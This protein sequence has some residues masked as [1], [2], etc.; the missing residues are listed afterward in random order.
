MTKCQAC[1]LHTGAVHGVA[2]VFGRGDTEAAMIIV[3]EAPGPNENI[4]GKPF[5]GFSGSI[6]SSL[7]RQAGV[8]EGKV[9]ITNA[10]GCWPHRLGTRKAETIPPTAGQ[11]KTCANLHLD[12]QL[13]AMPQARVLVTLGS[14]AAAA[15]F[16]RGEDDLVSL[17]RKISRELAWTQATVDTGARALVHKWRGRH[18]YATYHPAYLGRK[19]YKAGDDAEQHPEARLVLRTLRAAWAEATRWE[20]TFSERCRAAG[21]GA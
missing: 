2:P 13:A 14:T 7:L 19:N 20:E 10:V 6:L 11:V 21:C 9:W 16:G 8:D 12:Q 17:N 3:G 18:V 5:V 1:A 15:T 4:S